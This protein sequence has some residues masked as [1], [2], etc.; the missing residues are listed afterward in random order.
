MV[1]KSVR[2]FRT[3]SNLD[4]NY[5]LTDSGAITKEALILIEGKHKDNKG[6]VHEFDEER[7][8]TIAE[9][10]TGDLEDGKRIPLLEDHNRSQQTTIGDVEVGFIARE[11]TE[12]DPPAQKN[13]SL[14]GKFGVF[15]Q[16]VQVKAKRALQQLEENLLSTV[17]A[18]VDIVKNTV[19]EVSCTP[20]AAIDGMML[21]AEGENALTFEDL[22]SVGSQEEL[23]NVLTDIDSLFSDFMLLIENIYYSDKQEVDE[24]DRKDLIKKA[25]KGLSDRLEQVTE[26]NEPVKDTERQLRDRGIA[27]DPSGLETGFNFS[28]A[29]FN[30]L[31]A[32]FQIEKDHDKVKNFF[33]LQRR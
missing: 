5:S 13:P 26:L 17:S 21:F 14:I 20:K 4:A 11:I 27:L 10:A 3:P 18:G 23:S 7:L 16:E 12:N 6:R 15:A 29:D 8:T 9:N 1:T 31:V 24:H 33:Y 28:E 25:I 22:E 32:L 2:F 30:G 19:A